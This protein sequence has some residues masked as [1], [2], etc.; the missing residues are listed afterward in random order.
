LQMIY[1]TCD[2]VRSGGLMS[3]GPS[4]VDLFRQPPA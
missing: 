4:Y 2:F 1:S 3:Y